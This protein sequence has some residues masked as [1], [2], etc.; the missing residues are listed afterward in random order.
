MLTQAEN[1][2]TQLLHGVRETQ[3]AVSLRASLAGLHIAWAKYDWLSEGLT[4]AGHRAALPPG[5][6]DARQELRQ[7]LLL[8][9]S[10]KEKAQPEDYYRQAAAYALLG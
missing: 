6:D 4:R 8:L 2:Y 10:L 1:E 9:D 3:A 7:A 5:H